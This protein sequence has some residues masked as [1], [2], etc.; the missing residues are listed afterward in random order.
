MLQTSMPLE[1][2]D[3]SVKCF[4]STPYIEGKG[5]RSLHRF[6]F[7]QSPPSGKHPIGTFGKGVISSAHILEE[8]RLVAFLILPILSA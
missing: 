7:R 2:F 8:I 3:V 6:T 4:I 5:F 1:I